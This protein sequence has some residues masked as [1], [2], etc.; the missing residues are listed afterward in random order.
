MVEDWF[1]MQRLRRGDPVAL[2]RVYEKY[3]DYLLSV[4]AYLLADLAEAEDCL[5]DVFV[6]LA[7]RGSQL[8]VRGNLKGYLAVSVA[9]RARDSLRRKSRRDSLKETASVPHNAADVQP[10]A[11]QHAMDCE[12]ARKLFEA[13]AKLPDDQREVVALRLSVGMKFREIALRQEVSVNTVRSR[14]RYGLARLRELCRA[15]VN[16]ELRV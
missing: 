7:D 12:E 8:R 13:L 2:A 1:L 6:G 11:A 5:H 10:S 16:H 4:A 15:E 14:Y 3:K 9:N